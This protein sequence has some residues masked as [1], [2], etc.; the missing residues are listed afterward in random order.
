VSDPPATVV[1]TPVGDLLLVGDGEALT[2]VRFDDARRGRPNAAGAASGVLRDAAAQLREYFAGTRTAFELPL[3]VDG[4]PF[5]HRVWAEL[6][7]IPY[8]TTASYGLIAERVGDPGAARAVGRANARNPIPVIVPCHRVVG[9]DGSLTG[10][11]G[12]LAC[13]RRLLELEGALLPLG[14]A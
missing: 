3:R 5:E 13:K 4:S 12:G 6:R 2:G 11:G 8:G 14:P 10:F 1:V 9:A 7:R